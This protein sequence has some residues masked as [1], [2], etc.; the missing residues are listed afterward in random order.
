MRNCVMVDGM[1]EARSQLLSFVRFSPPG[2]SF[3]FPGDG[4]ARRCSKADM[5][6]ESG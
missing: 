6:L 4:V 2:R 3:I 5:A 1:K